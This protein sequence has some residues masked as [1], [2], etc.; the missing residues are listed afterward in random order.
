MS[1]DHAVAGSFRDPAGRVHDLE[2]RIFR[3]VTPAGAKDFESVL[4]TGFLDSLAADDRLVGYALVDD[5]TVTEMFTDAIYVLEHPRLDYISYPY[6]WSF[7][8]LKAAALH[9]LDIALDALK[10]GL[11]L[12]DATAYNVQFVGA[13]PIFID[14]LSFRPYRDREYWS[15][16]RQFCEQ[17]LNPLLLRSEL[18]IS[19]NSWFRGALEGISTEDIARLLPL[20]SRLSLR[21]NAHVFLPAHFQKGTQKTAVQRRNDGGQQKG[22]ARHGYE[23]MLRQLRNWVSGL[24]PKGGSQT[25]WSDY[26]DANTYDSAEAETKAELVGQF[27]RDQKASRVIDLGCNSGFFSQVAL[28][29][30]AE[31]V[32]GFDFDQNSLDKGF[33][34]AAENDLNFT[35]FFLDAANPSPSQ[36]WSQSERTGFADR[37]KADVVLALAFEHH[38]AIGKNVPLDQVVDWITSIAP[39]GIIEFV[40]KG[41]PTVQAMLSMREDIFPNYTEET[42]AEALGRRARIVN[43]VQI[44]GSGRTLYQFERKQ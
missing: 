42:F 2:G 5:E 14:H 3:T 35:S 28:K 7:S 29:A 44:T 17:F 39:A 11:V 38:L 33:Q 36:G 23:G 15:A 26:A 21:M 43:R 25:V 8:Q 12:S 6:E 4:E 34:R 32:V 27:V 13:R 9:Y 41:D 22:L 31:S 24:A 18:G 10:A 16:H 30:G 37:A 19:H 20:K 40:P 1:F